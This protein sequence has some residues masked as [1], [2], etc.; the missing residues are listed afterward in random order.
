MCGEIDRYVIGRYTATM[1]SRVRKVAMLYPPEATIHSIAG[2]QNIYEAEAARYVRDLILQMRDTIEGMGSS[3]DL[4][5]NI[6]DIPLFDIEEDSPRLLEWKRGKSVR[7][8]D[9]LATV[10][11]TVRQL[12]VLLQASRNSALQR[13]IIGSTDPRQFSAIQTLGRAHEIPLLT[14]QS[15]SFGVMRKVTS[16]N[17]G[18]EKTDSPKSMRSLQRALLFPDVPAEDATTRDEFFSL[19]VVSDNAEA[20][21]PE[22]RQFLVEG[23]TDRPPTPSAARPT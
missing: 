4:R 16:M 7:D 1:D 2:K 12:G 23:R 13:A 15:N 14:K 17:L 9:I 6:S 18:K 22:F 20:A 3:L 10:N 21:Q 5:F 19:E 11:P 8:A